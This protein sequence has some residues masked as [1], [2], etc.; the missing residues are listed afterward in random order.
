[1]AELISQ[2][3]PLGAAIA[4]AGLIAGLVAGLFGIGGG[5]VIV[6][7][8]FFCFTALG[9]A[10]TAM[11]VA[12]GTSLATIIATSMRSVMSH[13]EKGA[14]DWAVIRTWWPWIAVG[15]LIGVTIT[16]FFTSRGL[17]VVFG[18][19]G[20]A[21]SLQFVLGRPDWKLAQDMPRGAARIGLGGGLGALSA[22]LGIG[23]G[24]FGVTFMTLCGRAI[25]QAVATS[26]GFGVAIGAP[27]AL[28]AVAVGWGR[29]GLPPGSVGH[30]NLPA[31]ALIAV[32]TVAMA[33][34]GARLAHSLDAILLRRLFGV[35]LALAAANML[36]EAL[37]A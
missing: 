33:P 23:G 24:T 35:A 11:H 13:N 4:V 12:V 26:A 6:P 7:V 37:T 1:M 36:R 5:V 16:G 18:V 31:F 32:F 10:D 22:L 9:F 3:A 20:L 30:V 8:L 25:H 28:A 14:V 29:E 2:Y 17:A 15:A 27:G 34:V 19:V 21:L